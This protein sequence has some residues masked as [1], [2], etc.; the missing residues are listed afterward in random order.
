MRAIIFDWMGTLY[1]RNRGLFPYSERVLRGLKQ[2]YRLGLISLAKENAGLRVKEITDSGVY[3]LFDSVIVGSEK[4]AEVYMRCMRELDSTPETT[5]IVDDRAKR[6][7]KVGTELG[8][9][10]FWIQKG[11]YAHE[12]PSAETGEPTYRIDSIEDILD[13]I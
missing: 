12:L 6:G 13:I 11:E 5:S 3:S 2:R 7:I 1:E 4:N 9:Q 8:C 10:T